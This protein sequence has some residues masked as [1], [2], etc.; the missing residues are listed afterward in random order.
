[1]K[2]HQPMTMPNRT[3]T[4][5]LIYPAN[6]KRKGFLA[7]RDTKYQPLSLGIIA[8][9]TPTDWKVKIIDENF[10]DFRFYEA[11]LVGLTTFSSSATRAYEI[12]ALYREK[13]I[14][15]VLGGIH[16]SMM[17]DEAAQHVD[18]VVTG[19]AES[20]WPKL[21]ADFEAGS[22]QKRYKGN[23]LP[24]ENA[25]K[26]RRDLFHPGY[27]FASIQTT[28]GCPFD[29]NFC[30][31]SAFN[32]RHYRM[33]PIE[34][35]LDELEQIPQQNVFFLDDNIVGTSK[36][37]QERAIELFRKIVE[38]GIKKDWISQASLNLADNPEVLRW[39]AKSGARMIFIGVE[40]ELP[41]ALVESNKRINM[42]MGV[43]SYERVF[44]KMHKFG[45]AS[46]AGFMFG[47]DSDT[48]QTIQQRVDYIRRSSADSFQTTIVTPLPGTRLFTKLESEGRFINHNFPTDWQLFDYGDLV[49][50]PKLMS[51]PE[52]S[53][54]F[55]SA[56]QQIYEPSHLRRKFFKSWYNLGSFTTAYWSYMSNWNYRN[57]HIQDGKQ[58][59]N[60]FLKT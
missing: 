60:W 48:P 39:A 17:P 13:G 49:F 46:I 29:C 41:D 31:V 1:M 37:H 21:I 32:G 8:A 45:I 30:S 56:L 20:V 33:R 51:H 6:R 22:L 11:D 24:M 52:F 38:R 7:N 15:T 44:A 42:K 9:L 23:L 58:V 19:E 36:A 55:K 53:E 12:A 54:A 40:T 35:V 28:R 26:P 3:K 4:L 59:K 25:V 47:W 2:S 27:V 5:L 57:M 18:C 14:K 34:E 10:R 16:A 43:D 50:E